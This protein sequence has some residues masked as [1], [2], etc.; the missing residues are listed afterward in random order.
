MC[1]GVEEGAGGVARRRCVSVGLR[2]AGGGRQ[3]APEVVAA[4]EDNVDG[5]PER[6]CVLEHQPQRRRERPQ[7]AALRATVSAT[8]V[9]FVSTTGT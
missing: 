1:A 4:L 8:R 6:V 5:L 7:A 9:V 2:G 3:G